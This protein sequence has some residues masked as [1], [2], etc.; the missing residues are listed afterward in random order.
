[1]YWRLWWNQAIQSEHFSHSLHR[2]TARKAILTAEGGGHGLEIGDLGLDKDAQQMMD[3]M[4]ATLARMEQLLALES[5]GA[6]RE[7]YE[8]VAVV[9]QE[10]HPHLIPEVREDDV[11]NM[12]SGLS[13][14]G[15]A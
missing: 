15:R 1:M 11:A 12:S 14:L 4:R 3:T 2:V 5:E 13:R 10:G 8:P 6:F 7:D 9:G